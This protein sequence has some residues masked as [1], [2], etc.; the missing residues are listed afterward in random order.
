MEKPYY[1]CKFQN[2]KSS[3]TLNPDLKFHFTPVQCRDAWLKAGHVTTQYSA[4]TTIYFCHLH[5]MEDDFEDH[6]GKLRVKEGVV[7]KP[8]EEPNEPSASSAEVEIAHVSQENSVEIASRALSGE[9]AA[10]EIASSLTE[11]LAGS[12]FFS[13]LPVP[14][15]GSSSDDSESEEE[16]P[17]KKKK[18][19]DSDPDYE[20]SEPSEEEEEEDESEEFIGF[21]QRSLYHFHLS[22]A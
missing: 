20:D 19:D 6:Y 2:C 14:D 15:N 22:R 9:S 12:S 10:V 1:R 11:P 21:Y 16:Q 8:Y 17:N 7:P 5:F 18:K 4:K 13:S 3:S